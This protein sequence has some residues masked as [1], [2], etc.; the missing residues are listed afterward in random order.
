MK[1]IELTMKDELKNV[2]VI[3]NIDISN[4]M[5]NDTEAALGWEGQKIGT[6]A[7]IKNNLNEWIKERGNAQHDTILTLLYYKII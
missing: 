5:V 7:Q 3:R 6:D 2:T 4:A 1:T